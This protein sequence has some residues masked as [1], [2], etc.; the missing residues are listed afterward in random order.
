[1]DT[2]TT[3]PD[4]VVETSNDTNNRHR[5]KSPLHPQTVMR[6][7]TVVIIG[8]IVA[9]VAGAMSSYMLTKDRV[10]AIIAETAESQD[11]TAS[12]LTEVLIAHFDKKVE[13]LRNKVNEVGASTQ[14]A[15]APSD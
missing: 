3:M 7:L 1:M 12:Q 2:K 15:T 4:A 5:K 13:E 8:M 6:L 14:P 10:R 9:F 11:R